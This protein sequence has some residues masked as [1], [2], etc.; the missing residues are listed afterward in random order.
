M[1]SPAEGES[2][3]GQ[4]IGLPNV[5]QL[6]TVAEEVASEDKAQPVDPD[7]RVAQTVDLKSGS[8]GDGGLEGSDAVQQSKGSRRG[9]SARI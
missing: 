1:S 3:S 7:D 4:Q 2:T 8:D 9:P 5:D 6:V